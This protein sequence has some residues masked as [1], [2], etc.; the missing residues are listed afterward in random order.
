[1]Y[2]QVPREGIVIRIDNDPIRE[3]FK[4]KT[5]SFALGEAVLYDDADYVDIEVQ[6]GDYETVDEPEK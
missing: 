5:A 6:Q 1:L 3:A 2:Q 4:L